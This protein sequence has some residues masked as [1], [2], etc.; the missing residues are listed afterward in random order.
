MCEHAANV[1]TSSWSAG[2]SGLQSR[3]LSDLRMVHIDRFK[4]RIPE[5]ALVAPGVV[6]PAGFE[7]VRVSARASD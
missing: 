2:S 5:P 4:H 3:I 6:D 1:D 7:P